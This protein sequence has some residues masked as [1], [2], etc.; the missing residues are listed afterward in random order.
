VDTETHTQ[1]ANHAWSV[2]DL[3]RG[4]YKQSD[5]GKVILPFTVPRR[6]ESVLEPTRR[7]GL[8]GGRAVRR[9]RLGLGPVPAPRL[10]H[11]DLRDHPRPSRPPHEHVPRRAHLS[12]QDGIKV[13]DQIATEVDAIR[14]VLHG[15]ADQGFFDV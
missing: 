2:A 3:L 11:R 7:E 14:R 4:D 12:R 15:Y 10:G 5:Y 9:G 1:L 13:L 8:R 6:L